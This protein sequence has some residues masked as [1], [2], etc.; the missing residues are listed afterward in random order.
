MLEYGPAKENTVAVS[1]NATKSVY[2]LAFGGTFS[3]AG[4]SPHA[5]IKEQLANNL[6]STHNLALL[7]KILDET[8]HACMS[9]SRLPSTPQFVFVNE[10]SWKQ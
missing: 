8:Y 4:M 6:N 9:L 2:N 5:L 3:A 7:S 1:W 10:K